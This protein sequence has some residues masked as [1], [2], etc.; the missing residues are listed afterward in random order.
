MRLGPKRSWNIPPNF[1][2]SV[3]QDWATWVTG[4]LQ[5]LQGPIKQPIPP[6]LTTISH[7]GAVQIIWNEVN[8]ATAYALYET[9]TAIQPPGVPLAIVPANMATLAGSYLR[10][11]LNDTTTRYYS[12]VTITQYGRSAAS[13]PVA[14][15]ALSTGATIV[16]ISQTPVDQNGVGGGLG[17]GGGLFGVGQGQRF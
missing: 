11:G 15:T 6:Q 10:T 5:D 16:P 1:S 3:Q 7:P 12:A 4:A 14:G 17:G 13:T 2:D 8:Q 9:T